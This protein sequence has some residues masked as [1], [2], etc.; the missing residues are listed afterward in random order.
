MGLKQLNCPNCTW[1]DQVFINTSDFFCPSCGELLWKDNQPLKKR[2]Y[3][4][5]TQG[6]KPSIFLLSD[7][8]WQFVCE[9]GVG[10]IWATKALAEFNFQTHRQLHDLLK[11]TLEKAK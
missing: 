6:G 5:E 10:E 9:C 8:R 4:D 2:T 11:N 3:F 1:S 7:G